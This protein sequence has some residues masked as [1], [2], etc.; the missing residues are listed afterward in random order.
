MAEKAEQKKEAALKAPD[1]EKQQ[2]K[3]IPEIR[4]GDKVRVHQRIKERGSGKKKEARERIQIF[5]GTVLARKH[6]REP[7]ATLT[8][9]GQ[10]AGVGVER[11]FPLHSPLIAKIEVAEKR[12]ARRAKIYY[13]RKR[14]EREIRRKLKPR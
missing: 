13:I 1:K 14:S 9:R 11:I 10:V 3:V 12:K 2:G 7:G 8:V 4:P 6:G 5:E